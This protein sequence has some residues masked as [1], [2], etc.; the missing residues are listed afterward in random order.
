[1]HKS[2]KSK[3]MHSEVSKTALQK[4]AKANKSSNRSVSINNIKNINELLIHKIT[5]FFL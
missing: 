5:L 2:L 4:I 3:N 1:M